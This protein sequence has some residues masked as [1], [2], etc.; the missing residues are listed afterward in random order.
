ML[1]PG[2][3][4]ME[5]GKPESSSKYADEG[6][7]AHQ[8]LAWA[9]DQ[10]KLAAH[11]IGHRVDLGQRTWE[12]TVEMAQ[13]VQTA[14]D[15]IYIIAGPDPVILSEQRVCY[16][17]ALSVPADK[18]WGTADVISVR[19]SELQVHDYKHGMGVLVEADE[20]PQLMLYG[21]GALEACQGIHGDFD[22][23]RLVIHQ[24]RI[25]EAPS[26]WVISV[27][28]L[29]AWGAGRAR[30]AV[31]ER[32]RAAAL[33]GQ[34]PHQGLQISTATWEAMFLRPNDKSCKFCKA[35]ATCPK[36]RTEVSTAVLQ[37]EP[38]TP[39]EFVNSSVVAPPAA[40]DDADWLAVVL[41]KADL[42]D[43]YLSAV[44]AEVARRLEAGAA[45]PGFKL[46]A[47]KRGNRAWTDQEAATKLLR[48]TFRLKIEEAYDLKLISPTSAEKLHKD[49]V[50][51]PR[52]WPKALALITQADG[53]PSVAPASDKRPALV[54]KALA[55]EF[56][57]TGEEV[58]DF[59]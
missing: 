6:T 41:A 44:R 53:K 42:I 7:A 28:D 5:A 24:P 54:V 14:L 1:C 43:T 40:D 17:G 26:E 16:A 13:A 55:D 39:E 3:P 25:R 21:L 48:E 52:Q 49:G 56:E 9:I 12:V 15:N 30:S 46:V 32:Q 33:S 58:L 45:V 51:G 11:F 8:V 57:S 19:G 4:V 29:E 38:A 37:C 31:Y 34:R 47:S 35:K 20:N 59:A 2:K 18:G 22:T 36:L 10:D 23:V 50:I 27:A